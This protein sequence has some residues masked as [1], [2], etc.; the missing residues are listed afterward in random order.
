MTTEIHL[1]YVFWTG[2]DFYETSFNNYSGGQ[3]NGKETNND[4]HYPST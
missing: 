1:R 4:I 3:C 2:Q